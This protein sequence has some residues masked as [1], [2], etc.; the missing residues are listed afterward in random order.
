VIV[1]VDVADPPG[2]ME[3]GDSAEDERLKSGAAAFTVSVRTE[4]VLGR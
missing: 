3:D 4:D 2:A 1:I